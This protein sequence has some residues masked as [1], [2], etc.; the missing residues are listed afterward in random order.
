MTFSLEDLTSE[1]IKM[2]TCITVTA[3][4]VTAVQYIEPTII[5]AAANGHA[6]EISRSARSK[7]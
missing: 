4:Y 1:V 7:T 5:P 3:P 6:F 2:Y